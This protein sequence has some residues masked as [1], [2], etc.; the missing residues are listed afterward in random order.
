MQRVRLFGLT[1]ALTE[2]GLRQDSLSLLPTKFG[3]TYA[4]TE[5][6]LRQLDSD[7]V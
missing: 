7:T 1:Y 6:G 5:K 2:K 4:L 3:L